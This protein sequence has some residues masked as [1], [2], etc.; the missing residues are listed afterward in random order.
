MGK[1]LLKEIK[2]DDK[3]YLDIKETQ[4]RCQWQVTTHTARSDGIEILDSTRH[5]EIPQGELSPC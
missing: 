1:S 5:A 4:S 2:V 3:R